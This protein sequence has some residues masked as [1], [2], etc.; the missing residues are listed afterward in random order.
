MPTTRPARES[1]TKVVAVTV[2]P[3]LRASLR[4]AV[5]PSTAISELERTS[6]TRSRCCLLAAATSTLAWSSID[7]AMGKV[8]GNSLGL[9]VTARAE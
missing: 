6:V 5:A 7:D 1:T 2:R 3:A 4:K 9:N 8:L